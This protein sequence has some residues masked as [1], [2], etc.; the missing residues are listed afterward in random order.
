MAGQKIIYQTP[1]G[2]KIRAANAEAR[3]A[4]QSA[5]KWEEIPE[6]VNRAVAVELEA[7]SKAEEA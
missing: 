1:S 4:K 6:A 5:R 7:R 3:R 2:E